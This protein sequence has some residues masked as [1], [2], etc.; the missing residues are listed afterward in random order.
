MDFNSN[1]LTIPR[2]KVFFAKYLAGTQIPGPLRELGNCPEFTLTREEETLPHYSSQRGMRTKD[3]EL[4]IDS[5]LNGSVVTD[6]IKPANVA[7]WFG[8][9]VTKITATP[10]TALSETY[11]GIAAGDLYQL[12]R[13]ATNPSGARK[14]TNVVVNNGAAAG[15]VVYVA[16]VDYEVDAELGTVLILP[17][18]AA[19]GGKVK[20][21]FDVTASTRDQIAS[22]DQQTEGELKFVSYNPTGPQADVTIPRARLKA[23]GDLALLGDPESPEFMTLPLA[24]SVLKKG[25]LALAYRDGRPAA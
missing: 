24:I 11:E 16:N 14:I 15:P 18:A 17:G 23:N 13:T 12:G 19:T 5:T 2:G 22:G 6:D 4:T 7:Y 10:Q 8:S 3:E 9:S 1:N 25:N 21:T 20:I